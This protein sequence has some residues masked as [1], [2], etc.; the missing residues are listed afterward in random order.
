MLAQLGL[1]DDGDGRRRRLRQCEG[2]QER[3]EHW[4]SLFGGSQPEPPYE[5]ADFA[6]HQ[7]EPRYVS[8][9]TWP[10][11]ALSSAASTMRRLFTASVQ[12]AVRVQILRMARSKYACSR[13]QRA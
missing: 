6:A 1:E 11:R 5:D 7:P 8:V 12:W 10:V 2:E 13:S 9:T 4:D 3:G